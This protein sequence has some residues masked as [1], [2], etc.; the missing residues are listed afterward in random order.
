MIP[1]LK[2]KTIGTQW[3]VVLE[4]HAAGGKRKLPDAAWDL[5]RNLGLYA[6]VQYIQYDVWHLL[7]DGTAVCTDVLYHMWT[8][9]LSGTRALQ[10][11]NA[12]EARGGKKK[13]TTA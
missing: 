11:R 1:Y 5:Q 13:R 7:G 8:T 2:P 9:A 3:N 12:R 10:L 6:A 4:L